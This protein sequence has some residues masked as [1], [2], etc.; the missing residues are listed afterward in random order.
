MITVS[1][2]CRCSKCIIIAVRV[3]TR[4]WHPSTGHLLAPPALRKPSC[5]FVDL[6]RGPGSPITTYLPLILHAESADGLPANLSTFTPYIP[7]TSPWIYTS[8]GT[9]KFIWVQSGTIKRV[10]AERINSQAIPLDALITALHKL[11]LHKTFAMVETILNM[12]LTDFNSKPH[13][14]KI[15]RDHIYC[16]IGVRFYPPQGSEHY[17]LL[18]LYML[19]G[20]TQHQTPSNYKYSKNYDRRFLWCV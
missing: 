16:A 1:R 8:S 19:H 3:A 14:R 10:L 9:I 7:N 4:L 5:M 15:L 12:K 11:N 18:C 2:K 13:G 6:C 17:K 20:S